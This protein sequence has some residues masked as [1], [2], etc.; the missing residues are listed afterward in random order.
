MNRR[1]PPG[2]PHGEGITINTKGKERAAYGRL[3]SRPRRWAMV[4]VSTLAAAGVVLVSGTPASAEVVKPPRGEVFGNADQALPGSYIVQLKSTAFSGMNTAQAKANVTSSAKALTTRHGGKVTNEYSVVLKGFAVT[5]LSEDQAARLAADQSVASVSRDVLQHK[6]DTQSYPVWNLDRVDQRSSALDYQYTYPNTAPSVTAYVIDTGLYKEHG[7][8]GGR[9]SWG[10]NFVDRALRPA[11][12]PYGRNTPEHNLPDNVSDCEGHG[13][14]VAGTIGGA[15]YG[16]AKQVKIVAV[17]VLDC[18]GGGWTSEVVAGIEWVTANAV[19]PAV[20]NMS[21]GGSQ[22]FPTEDEAVRK[23]IASGLTYTIAA[24]NGDANDDPVNAC[25]MS[26]ARVPD[27]LTVGGSWRYNGRDYPISWSNY[28][29]CVDILA[30]G[31]DIWSASIAPG[32]YAESL[33][34]TSMAAP[35]VAGAAA[36]ILQTHPNY[37]PSQVR[38]ALIQSATNGAMDMYGGYGPGPAWNST[39]NRLLY[40]RQVDP[41]AIASKPVGINNQRFGTT[42]V[43]GRTTDNRIVYAY[44]AGTEWS[45]WSDLGGNTQGD[46]AVLYNPTYGTTEVYARLSNNHLAYRYYSNGWSGWNDLGGELAGNPAILYNPK[47]GTTEIYARFADGTLKYKYYANGWSGWSDLGGSIASDP[48]LLYNPK[49]GTTEVYV[50]TT[51]NKLKYKYY[52]N[53]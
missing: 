18:N 32:T 52:N 25:N 10:K 47:Y 4:G 39:A 23:S 16:V 5:G 17:R 8:F 1:C 30:P 45:D 35:H 14:H 2:D 3:V 31:G 19:K 43:Y 6:S 49:Y 53:G 22:I 13:T 20:V 41:P 27:A 21:L 48:A 34:G 37:T 26:P 51:D 42:E 33:W 29:P 36:L 11:T 15:T 24:G 12:D 38:Q 46:P 7:E 44:R 28:G 50:R 40:V 9:G